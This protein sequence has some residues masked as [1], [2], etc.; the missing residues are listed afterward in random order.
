MGL[1]AATAS[2]LIAR[3]GQSAGLLRAGDG[4]TDAFGHPIPGPD[5]EYP[6]TVAMVE[7]SIKERVASD[8][9]VAMGDKKVLA[10]VDG[11]SI[12]PNT[13]D[14]LRVGGIEWRILSVG[15]VAPA[16]DVFFY[17]IQA[18]KAGAT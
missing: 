7:F 9:I 17:E 3:H 10:S 16:G 15:K 12:D 1:N 6:V 14:R 5:T 4:G 8:G 2:R 13:S 18:R 11:L